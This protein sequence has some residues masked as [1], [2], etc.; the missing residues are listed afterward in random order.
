[1]TELQSNEICHSLH[2]FFDYHI[3]IQYFANISTR[4]APIYLKQ[5]TEV[6]LH[7]MKFPAK[8]QGEWIMYDEMLMYAIIGG[9]G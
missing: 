1:M 7:G 5:F 6:Y 9:F 2:R 3:E 4:I 8:F